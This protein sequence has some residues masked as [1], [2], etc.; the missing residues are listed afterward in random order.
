MSATRMARSLAFFDLLKEI[1]V[2]DRGVARARWWD[3]N[4]GLKGRRLAVL[5]VVVGQRGRW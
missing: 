1:V 5:A 4:D 2:D 3:A